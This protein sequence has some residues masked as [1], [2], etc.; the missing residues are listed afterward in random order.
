MYEST[1]PGRMTTINTQ[2]LSKAQPITP[3]VIFK[4]YI[5][6]C[7]YNSTCIVYSMLLH[8][9]NITTALQNSHSTKFFTGVGEEVTTSLEK[10]DVRGHFSITH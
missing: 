9:L 6:I 5:I 4:K 2:R 3:H 1:R 10:L 7:K 8:G